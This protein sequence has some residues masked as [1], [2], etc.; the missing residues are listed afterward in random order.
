MTADRGIAGTSDVGMPMSERSTTSDPALRVPV[1]AVDVVGLTKRFGDQVAV[2]DLSI[3]VPAGII[4]GFAGPNGAGK[5]TTMR[6]LLGLVTPDAGSGTV[7]GQP[8]GEPHRY[9][10]RV[11]ALVE[12]P[13]FYPSLTG[14]DNLR[15]LARLGGIDCSRVDDALEL[16]GLTRRAQDPYRAYPHGMKQRLGIAAALLPRSELLLLDEPANGLDPAGIRGIRALLAGLADAGTTILV[17]SLGWRAHP[18]AMIV[19]AAIAADVSALSARCTPGPGG[20]PLRSQRMADDRPFA[21]LPDDVSLSRDEV[22][23]V[24][25]AL[26][27]FDDVAADEP[28]RTAI[29]RA[30][31]VLITKLWPELGDLLDDEGEG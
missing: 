19:P 30:I 21:H 8:L 2:D 4:A 24:L 11:G 5:T 18:R 27:L 13:A 10:P 17:A 7:L 29:R 23:V 15:L 1:A 20:A 22:A 28:A 26:D 31:R 9:L 6:M 25:F 3:T 14:R 16:V 12:S